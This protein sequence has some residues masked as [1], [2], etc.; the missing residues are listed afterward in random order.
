MGIDTEH[1]GRAR[2]A[3]HQ[4][5]NG[6]ATDV[7]AGEVAVVGD[8]VAELAEGLCAR[9]SG[10]VVEDQELDLRSDFRMVE[11]DRLDGEVCAVVVIVGRHPDGQLLVAGWHRI[12]AG[13]RSL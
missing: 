3:E 13:F 1:V 2:L 8:Q 10:M 6:R 9:T 4:V 11:A 5:A 12:L 7:V